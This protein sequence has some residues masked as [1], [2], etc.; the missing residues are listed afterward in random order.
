MSLG[1]YVDVHVPGPITRGLRRRGVDVLTA[2]DDGRGRAS[3]PDLLD[4]AF[5][6][7]R[8]VFSQDEDMLT[9][10]VKSHRADEPFATVIF[11]R[12]LDLSLGG[13]SQIWKRSQKPPFRKMLK[14]RLFF[15]EKA[16]VGGFH[17]APGFSPDLNRAC[18]FTA[19]ICVETSRFFVQGCDLL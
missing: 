3:D 9:E 14:G 4:R 1:L 18:P 11:V 5:E 6:L 16:L 10:A 19:L 7:G 12:Q 2:Q 17:S 8:M 15:S 13:A